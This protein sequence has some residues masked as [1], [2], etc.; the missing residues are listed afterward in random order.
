MAG[1]LAHRGCEDVEMSTGRERR[2]DPLVP[3][4]SRLAPEHPRREL[5]LELHARAIADGAATYRD[6]DTGLQV[7]TAQHHLDRGDC[8]DSGCRHCPYVVGP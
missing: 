5:I 4:P 3:H 2:I 8:C 7:F 6:P 1:S